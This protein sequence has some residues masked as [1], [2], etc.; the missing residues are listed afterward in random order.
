[1]SHL[2]IQEDGPI[3]LKSRRD[4]IKTVLY[5]K[6]LLKGLKPFD[7]DLDILAEL[8]EFGCYSG[9]ESQT[10]FFDI[11]LKK[12]LRNSIASARNKISEL[13]EKGILFRPYKNAIRFNPDFLPT[14]KEI[15]FRIGFISKITH[16]S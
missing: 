6:Y 14:V 8:F 1:M 4:V 3:L 5:I 16:A 15:P 7:N 12:E 2:I 11:L 9:K 10:E 13:T